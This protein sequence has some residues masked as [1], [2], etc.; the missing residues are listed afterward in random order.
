ML[1]YLR[2]QSHKSLQF[3]TL[4]S[5]RD[6]R[7]QQRLYISSFS[8]FLKEE[9]EHCLKLP[10]YHGR[11][12]IRNLNCLSPSSK[13]FLPNYD[14]LQQNIFKCFFLLYHSYNSHL[15]YLPQQ[16]YQKVIR[17][18]RTIVQK[19]IHKLQPY[20]LLLCNL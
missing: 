1:Q 20:K 2:L 11:I 17:F 9:T 16:C 13:L 10:K 12:K 18:Y 8:L 6:F 19:L 15:K 3:V 4:L 5:K 14:S 7:D